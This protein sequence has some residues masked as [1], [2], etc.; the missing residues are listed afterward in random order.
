MPYGQEYISLFWPDKGKIDYY[1]KG[2][3]LVNNKISKL[4]TIENRENASISVIFVY[5]HISSILQILK[6]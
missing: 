5:W 4:R 6:E 3:K 2:P 1:T